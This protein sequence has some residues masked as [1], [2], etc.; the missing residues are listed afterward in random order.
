MNPGNKDALSKLSE[1]MPGVPG[2][3]ATARS[4]TIEPDA[5]DTKMI[6]D[7]QQIIDLAASLAGDNIF[8]TQLLIM[9]CAE[10]LRAQIRE[11]AESD[12]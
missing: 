5:E 4:V 11:E 8:D 7:M 3:G 12:E 2:S 9:N 6:A 10:E 1:L